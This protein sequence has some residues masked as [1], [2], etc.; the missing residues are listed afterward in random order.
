[1][2]GRRREVGFINRAIESEPGEELRKDDPKYYAVL[3]MDGDDM[4]QWVSGV[5]TPPL[6][7]VL[8]DKAWRYFQNGKDGLG[9]WKPATAGTVNGLPS[10]AKSVRR[11]LSPGFHAALSEAIS[12]FG[13]YCAGQIVEAF[14]GQLLYS[15]GDDV[16]AMLPA[17]KA[18][19]CAFALQCALRGEIPQGC[20][21]AVREKLEGLF[22][23]FPDAAG[24]L[25]CRNAGKDETLRPNWPLMVPGNR[26]TASVGIAIGHVRSPMQDTIQAA[27]DAESAAKAVTGKSAFCLSVLKR[28]GE[29]ADFVARWQSGVAGVWAELETNPDQLTGRFPY[30]FLQLIRP[31]LSCS[32]KDSDKG[33]EPRWTGDLMRS[34]EAEL[35]HVHYQ[36]SESKAASERKRAVARDRARHWMRQLVGDSDLAD[37]GTFQ[38]ALTPRGFVHFWMAWAFVNRLQEQPKD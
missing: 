6:E 22:E 7:C 4:G 26:A 38:A 12:D 27:R 15:G 24:F 13:L 9:G 23:F 14:G 19:D 16:L 3:C 11:P 8:A 35:C 21:R 5:K 1:V 36:Q 33:W 18:L 28:S 37:D 29:A 32:R 31:L 20:P 17:A 2:A 30:R 25:R 10:D 34:V